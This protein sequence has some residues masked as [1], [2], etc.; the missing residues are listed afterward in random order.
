MRR[1]PIAEDTVIWFSR[2]NSQAKMAMK[3]GYEISMRPANVAFLFAME[4]QINI[5]AISS[6]TASAIE[7]PSNLRELPKA[8][9]SLRNTFVKAK[10]A[11]KITPQTKL[12]NASDVKT[13]ICLN[14]CSL[15]TY[16]I[17]HTI[18]APSAK[19]IHINLYLGYRPHGSQL[20]GNGML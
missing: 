11:N 16:V 3:M 7:S 17:P 20:F 4:R 9:K 5:S 1:P 14:I 12:E 15:K 18:D 10:P 8:T 2:N 13:D 6:A 19:R